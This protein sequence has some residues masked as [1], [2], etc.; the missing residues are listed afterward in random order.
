[1]AEA[2]AEERRGFKL[3][4]VRGIQIRIDYSWFF[5]FALVLVSLSAGYFPRAYPNQSLQVYWSVGL[6]ATLLF[7]LSVILHELAHSFMA[8]RLGIRI[9]E[10]TL[11]LFGGVSQLSEDASDPQSEFKIA[12]VGPLTSFALAVLFGLVYYL[13]R[14][15]Q[16]S[17]VVELFGYLSW[18]NVAL[19]IFN[20]LPGYPLDG[21]RVLRAVWWWKTGSVVEATRK[22]SDWGKGLAIALMVL[23]GLQ[24]FAGN[25]IG[26][27]WIILIALFLRGIAEASYQEVAMRHAIEGTHIGDVM[28][29]DVVAASPDMPVKRAIS[30]LFLRHGYRG[31]PVTEDGRV[32]G[33]ISL[34]NVKALSDEEQEKKT[35][36]DVMQPLSSEMTVGEKTPVSEVLKRSAQGRPTHFFVMRDDTMIGM[37]THTRMLRY[38]EVRRA[39]A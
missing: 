31:F 14:G 36:R 29:Q 9:P 26:G 5:I 13:I 33:V 20:L 35:V 11:F 24:I 21:G 34:A 8:M 7:F 37:V 4:T 2:A 17:I 28:I 10:I 23:G 6:L 25:L 16:P 39:L 1:M 22:A 27:V 3:I 38:M 18:I 12:V 30:D 32:L 19:G 15:E